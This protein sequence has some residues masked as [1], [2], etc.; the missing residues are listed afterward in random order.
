[1]RG[2]REEGPY[3]RP[4]GREGAREEGPTYHVVRI[5]P[6]QFA[7]D[8]FLWRLPVSPEVPDVIQHH[9]TFGEQSTMSHLGVK[10]RVTRMRRYRRRQGRGGGASPQGSH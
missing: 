1:M 9:T 2:A 7:H 6:K 5:R 10:D 3:L 4:S 8:P